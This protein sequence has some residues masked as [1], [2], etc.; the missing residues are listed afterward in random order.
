MFDFSLKS[1]DDRWNAGSLDMAD[2]LRSLAA[3]GLPKDM[4]VLRRD[5]QERI[6]GEERAA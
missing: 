3:N 6:S 5:R 1:V 2:A 4:L